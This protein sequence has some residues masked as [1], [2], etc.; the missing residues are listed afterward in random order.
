MEGN[1][2]KLVFVID[3]SGSMSGTETDVIGG[4]NG[5]IRK[6]K[7]ETAGRISVSLY[8]F[9][10]DVNAVLQNV[11]MS[12]LRELN[13][14][15]YQPR[16]STALLDAIGRAIIEA[17]QHIN[18]AIKPDKVMM[19]VITDGYENASR[20]YSKTD[21]KTML[22]THQH[23]LNWEIMYLGANFEDFAEADTLG[24]KNQ[25]SYESCDMP[26]MMEAMS[27]EVNKYRS[28]KYQK[29][30]DQLLNN[31]MEYFKDDAKESQI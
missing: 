7:E 26:G 14:Q 4:F 29:D 18:F 25:A 9:N 3:E 30:T 16:G 19:I 5:F 2:L 27:N 10:S 13:L 12:D 28:N 31:M 22:D 11:D 21:I 6:Q 23:Q 15:N 8:K 1:Y 17:D 24:L 20:K